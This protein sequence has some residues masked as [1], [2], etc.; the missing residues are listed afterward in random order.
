MCKARNRNSRLESKEI[1]SNGPSL[2]GPFIKI[3]FRPPKHQDKK[4]TL[5]CFWQHLWLAQIYPIA[6][7]KNSKKY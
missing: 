7:A 5:G 2:S 3:S 1:L 6:K 4:P